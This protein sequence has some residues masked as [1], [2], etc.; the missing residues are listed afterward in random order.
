MEVS[1]TTK[2]EDICF[3]ANDL[4]ESVNYYCE[5]RISNIDNWS[6]IA[7]ICNKLLDL[8]NNGLPEIKAEGKKE[9]Q[10]QYE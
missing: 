3:V 4:L 2:L 8:L 7:H 9:E 1:P 5:Y 6:Y 10:H